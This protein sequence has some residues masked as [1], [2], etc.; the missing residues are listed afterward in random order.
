MTSRRPAILLA[1]FAAGALAFPLST[2]LAQPKKDEKD[3]AKQKATA[4]AN[5]R[6]ADLAGAK[7]IETDHFV[8]ATTLPEEKAKAL[9]AVLE[10]ITPVVRKA[11]QFEEKEEAWKGKLAVYFLPEG[12]EFKGFMRSVVVDQPDGIHYDLRAD[13]PFVVDPVDVAGKPTEADQFAHT[14]GVVAGAYL[15]ARGRRAPCRAG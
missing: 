15:K 6:K 12:R 14:A 7:V 11:A 1:A 4:V 8:V 2:G 10:K 3:G 13:N 9:G 5:M